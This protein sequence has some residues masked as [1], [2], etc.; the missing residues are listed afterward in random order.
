[1]TYLH[2]LYELNEYEYQQELNSTLYYNVDEYGQIKELYKHQV[3][4]ENNCYGY[5][6]ADVNGVKEGTMY[7]FYPDGQLAVNANFLHDEM[8]GN[9]DMYFPNQILKKHISAKYYK[10]K[11][12]GTL[13]EYLEN[14][15]LLRMEEYKMGIFEGVS[16][17]WTYCGKRHKEKYYEGGV[18]KYEKVYKNKY[19][20]ISSRNI[21]END[22]KESVNTKDPDFIKRF[23][24]I[25][26]TNFKKIKL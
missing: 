18:L 2:P 14:G 3:R 26:H 22:S 15:R 13:F 4:L 11:L 17:I 6:Y 20:L 23:L 25:K 19:E 8:H 16:K 10:N 1:M 7:I 12:H 9:F 5:F 21:T 24:I